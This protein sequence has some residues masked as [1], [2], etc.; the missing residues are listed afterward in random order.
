MKIL[1]MMF[2]TIVTVVIAI[3]FNDDHYDTV[4]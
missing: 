2:V 1:V 4:Q 3:D